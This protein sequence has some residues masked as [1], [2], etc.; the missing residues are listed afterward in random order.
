MRA[1]RWLLV[2]LGVAA[3][4]VPADAPAAA[5]SGDRLLV[6]SATAGFRHPSIP[7]AVRT[8]RALGE[9][10]GFTVDATEDPRRFTRRGLDRY[11]ALVFVSTTGNVLPE[12]SQRAALERYVRGGG[13]WLG[14]HAA[15]DLG[16]LATAWPW[17]RGLVGATFRGHSCCGA[18]TRAAIRVEATDTASTRGLPR[19]WSRADEWYGFERSPRSH[20]RVLASLDESTYVPGAGA[21]GPV[22][23]AGRG[24]A[25]TDHPIAW[26][27]RY[28]GGRS[29]Y[30]G[31]GHAAAAFAEPA[32]RGHLLG[33]MRMA[34]GRAPFRC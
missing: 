6:Y 22:D 8:I 7:A 18:G 11:A 32:V 3:G 15:A 19:R 4:W 29:V 24:R 25:A 16:P 12:R 23:A 30:T 27:R 14:I 10:A 20:V 28:D 9:R 21:M 1:G 34:A 26:C 5:R 13:G 2:G 31:L 33:S 17:Y